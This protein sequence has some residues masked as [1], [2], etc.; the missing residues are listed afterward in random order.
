MVIPVVNTDCHLI[1]TNVNK[2]GTFVTRAATTIWN[3]KVSIFI[4]E[5]VQKNKSEAFI[6]HSVIKRKTYFELI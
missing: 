3:R 2:L 5:S 1:T 4:D 6:L